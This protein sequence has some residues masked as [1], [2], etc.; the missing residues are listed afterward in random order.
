MT[1]GGFIERLRISA[2]PAHLCGVRSEIRERCLQRSKCTL[3]FG[4]GLNEPVDCRREGVS[5]CV[6]DLLN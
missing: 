3:P 4:Q 6:G 2:D 5:K 1:I